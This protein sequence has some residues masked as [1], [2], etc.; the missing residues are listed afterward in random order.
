MKAVMLGA[1]VVAASATHS[2]AQA[3]CADLKDIVSIFGT[4]DLSKLKSRRIVGMSSGCMI[5]EGGKTHLYD[6]AQTLSSRDAAVAR[7]K[8]IETAIEQCFPQAKPH[9]TSAPDTS[10]VTN[11]FGVDP[12]ISKI[13]VSTKFEFVIKNDFDVEIAVE[14]FW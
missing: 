1:L 13:S 14:G 12:R 5:V 8:E 4:R 3:L 9:R 6:C 11:Y 2:R 7:A 10:T